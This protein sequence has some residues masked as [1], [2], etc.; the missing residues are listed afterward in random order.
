MQIHEK[1]VLWWIPLANGHPCHSLSLVPAFSSLGMKAL[2]HVK[3]LSPI[4]LS[5]HHMLLPECE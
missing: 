2:F 4:T 5:Y 3:N 1:H